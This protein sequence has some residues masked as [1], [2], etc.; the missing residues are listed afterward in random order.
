MCQPIFCLLCADLDVFRHVVLIIIVYLHLCHGSSILHGSA[1][2]NDYIC[3]LV[4]TDDVWAEGL[5]FNCGQGK[6]ISVYS[7]VSRL[8]LEPIQPQP[9]GYWVSFPR[10][11]ADMV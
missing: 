3:T 11:R 9:S 8:A 5:G 7:T 4:A 6:G 1:V 2:F 10:D